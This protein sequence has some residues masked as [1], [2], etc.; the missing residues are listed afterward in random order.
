MSK[1]PYE[2]RRAELVK[3]LVDAYLHASPAARHDG[4]AWY[5]KARRIVAEWAESYAL[6]INTVASVVAA[7]SPQC[8][9]SR[10]LVIADDVLAERAISIGGALHKNIDKARRIRTSPNHTLASMMQLFPHGPKVNCFAWN[11]AGNDRIVTIDTHMGQA[12]CA[13]VT[14]T[15]RLAWVVYRI[16]AE[17][18]TIAATRVGIMPATFQAIV[19]H[20]WKERY[21][22]TEKRKKRA[23]W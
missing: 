13:D 8:D 7:I 22:R 1:S 11:L 5:P 14:A 17:C 9:W 10:N 12:A 21:P 16:F 6:P 2:T 18:T 4:H 20:A 3:N 23:R 15:P 19:W